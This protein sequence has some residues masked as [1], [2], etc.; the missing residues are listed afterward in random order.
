[1]NKQTEGLKIQ[2][3]ALKAV[4]KISEVSFDEKL[5]GY[6]LSFSVS[7]QIDTI[8]MNLNKGDKTECYCAPFD[9]YG[10]KMV[11]FQAPIP[12]NTHEIPLFEMIVE[13]ALVE[14]FEFV[15]GDSHE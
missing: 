2:Q 3:S 5:N 7:K 1:M 8:S 12:K 4:R 15:K 14:V 11:F 13:K 6:S 10:E 9:N